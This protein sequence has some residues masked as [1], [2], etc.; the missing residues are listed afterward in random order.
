MTAHS[1]DASTWHAP[2]GMVAQ[3][4]AD[5]SPPGATHK[6][7]S[8]ADVVF[9]CNAHLMTAINVQGYGVIYLTPA[10]LADWSA[11]ETV[12]RFDLSTLRTSPRDWIDLW[13]SPYADHLQLP[14]EDWLPDLNGPPR[15]AI[16]IKMESLNGTTPFKAFVYRNF[17]EEDLAG[18]AETGY[19]SFLEP[20]ALRRDTFELRLSRTH[21]KFGM[22]AY[23]F[24]WVDTDLA[25]LGWDQGVVQFGHHSYDPTRNCPTCG[26]NTWHWDNV[27]ISSAIPFTMLRADRRYVDPDTE[28]GVK[29]PGPSPQG[30]RLRFAGVGRNIEVSFDGGVSWEPAQ[31]QTQMKYDYTRFQSYWTPIPAGV[32]SVQFRGE[33]ATPGLPWMV[34]DISIWSR[35]VPAAVEQSGLPQEIGAGA[36]FCPLPQFGFLSQ[37]G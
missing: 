2:E 26:P 25:D 8:Y 20:S 15:N 21:L 7:S 27:Y 17:Q 37:H 4:G 31:L 35:E 10:Q 33:S 14:L 36:L 11:G 13:I 30:S 24:W 16:H 3:H 23:D 18:N 32:S 19:E 1:R 28:P 34:Q 6:I 5:C 12:I 22:P 29:F 9:I